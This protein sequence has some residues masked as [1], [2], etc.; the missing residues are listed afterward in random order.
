MPRKTPSLLTALHDALRSAPVSQRG[1][2]LAALAKAY[3][4]QLDAAATDP[5]V[6]SKVLADLG[7]KF[8]AALQ[9]LGLTSDLRDAASSGGNAGSSPPAS[10]G[11]ATATASGTAGGPGEDPV[12]VLANLRGRRVSG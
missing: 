2:A 4:A 1:T 6:R 11:S 3:A 10:R 12:V 7:P 9:A 5:E 8:L